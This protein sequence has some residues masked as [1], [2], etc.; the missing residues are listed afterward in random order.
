MHTDPASKINPDY[1]WICF[2]GSHGFQTNSSLKERGEKNVD[3]MPN[4]LKSYSFYYKVV[5]PYWFKKWSSLKRHC[6]LQVVQSKVA[7]TESAEW[8]QFSDCLN[9]L[10]KNNSVARQPWPPI[11]TFILTQRTR[12]RHIRH[13]SGA[14][15]EA[16]NCVLW[17]RMGCFG[18]A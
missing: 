9:C 2:N 7:V 17:L 8:Q 6:S 12:R 18:S 15:A 14:A 10:L 4:I 13:V 5:W 1:K 16:S 3:K 11:S